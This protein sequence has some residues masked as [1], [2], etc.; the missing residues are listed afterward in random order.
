M[1]L[2][3]PFEHKIRSAPDQVTAIISGVYV[4]LIFTCI[5]FSAEQPLSADAAVFLYSGWGY[6]HGHPPYTF[7]WDVKAPAIGI[8]TAAFDLL[9]TSRIGTLWLSRVFTGGVVIATGA[10]ITDVVSQFDD[11]GD[12]LIA[13]GAGI[14]IFTLPWFGVGFAWGPY[15]YFY[16]TFA[17]VAAVWAL[18]TERWLTAGIMAAVAPAYWQF[19]APIALL[20]LWAAEDKRQYVTGF[21]TILAIVLGVLIVAGNLQ[22]ALIQTIVVP[23]IVTPDVANPF[24]EAIRFYTAGGGYIGLFARL[25]G[26]V[27]LTTLTLLPREVVIRRERWLIVVVALILWFGPIGIALGKTGRVHLVPLV[28]VLSLGAGLT[29][30]TL[31]KKNII[32]VPKIGRVSV[33]HFALAILAVAVAAIWVQNIVLAEWTIDHSQMSRAYLD[34]TPIREC[35]MRN[36]W[37]EK[38]WINLVGKPETPSNCLSSPVEII[39]ILL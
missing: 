39:R 27:L 11:A 3:T 21:G 19:T 36:S 20:G 18:Q 34:G 23:L 33:A 10:L 4:A 35:H 13:I 6:L 1:S 38:E 15:V 32:E 2:R 8:T 7:L 25:G 22:Q 31:R 24:Q 9:T 12:G 30:P 17:V 28:A 5:F 16:A 26:I 29:L 37:M 14:S